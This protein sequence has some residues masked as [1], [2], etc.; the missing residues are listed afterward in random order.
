MLL[1]I[2]TTAVALAAALIHIGSLSVHLMFL[3]L[4]L[5]AL[6]LFVIVATVATAALWVRLHAKKGRAP[7]A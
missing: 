3:S 1:L 6:I 5:K 2:S 7:V 4:L